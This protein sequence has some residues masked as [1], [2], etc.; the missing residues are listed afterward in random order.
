MNQTEFATAVSLSTR[1]VR[2]LE[3]EGLPCRS[4]K[5]EKWYPPEALSWYWERKEREIRAD[6]A[7]SDYQRALTR[8]T[9]ADARMAELKAAQLEEALIPMAIHQEVLGRVLDRIRARFRN[10]PGSWADRLVGI[11]EPGRMLVL[12][13]EMVDE[14]SSELSSDAENI[15]ANVRRQE[16]P[17]EF[18][19]VTTLR[20]AGIELFAEL[21]DRDDLTS[22]PGV[23]PVRA[24]RIE[25]GLKEMGLM[26]EDAA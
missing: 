17:P 23:G 13:R 25:E 14:V 26:H 5:N 11:T 19:E 4:E 9:L 1:Q 22:I 21:L 24:R 12:L 6:A 10:I 16:I 20:K 18:P 2:N 15:V 3:A 7:D 8:K